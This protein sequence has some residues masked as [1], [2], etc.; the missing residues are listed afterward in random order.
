MYT[1]LEKNNH[2]WM[3]NKEQQ[4]CRT[5]ALSDGGLCRGRQ[6]FLALRSG[7]N[8]L[9]SAVMERPCRGQDFPGEKKQR[10]IVETKFEVVGR[11][12]V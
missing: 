7:V 10:R 5:V 11:H 3:N 8:M 2:N 4:T 9:V 12:P 1:D 6:H